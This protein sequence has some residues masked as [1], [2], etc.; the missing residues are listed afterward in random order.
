MKD[1]DVSALDV[2]GKIVILKSDGLTEDEML[3][4][5]DSFEAAGAV[6]MA[7][8]ALDETVEAITIEEMEEFLRQ[9]KS[10]TKFKGTLQ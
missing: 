2:K 5:Y 4:L 7:V 10:K 9:A 6:G 3:A 1:K 8:L